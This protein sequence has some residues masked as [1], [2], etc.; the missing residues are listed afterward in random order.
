V[1]NVLIWSGED[2]ISDT[3]LPRFLAAGGNKD[4]L[5]FVSDRDE[6]G[7]ARPFDPSTDMSKLYVGCQGA[8]GHQASTA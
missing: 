2:G 7:E 8:F 1:G 6:N 4:R 3:L 5:H